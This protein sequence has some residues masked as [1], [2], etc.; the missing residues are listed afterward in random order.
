MQVGFTGYYMRVR[1]SD[2]DNSLDF[3]IMGYK[4]S[5]KYKLDDYYSGKHYISYGAC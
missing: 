3:N 4:G 1:Y 5:V 2:S